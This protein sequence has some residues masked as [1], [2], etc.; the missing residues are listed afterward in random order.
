[1][2]EESPLGCAEEGVGFDV[3]G[4]CARADSAHLVLEEE[5]ADEGF[6]KTEQL[7]T[8]NCQQVR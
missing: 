3:G 7:A 1:M 6:T 4:A 2:S 8:P 5:F